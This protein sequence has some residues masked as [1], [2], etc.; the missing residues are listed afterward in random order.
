M[1]TRFLSVIIPT[2]NEKDNVVKLITE[3]KSILLTNNITFEIIFVDDASDDGTAELLD[4]ISS[5]IIKVFHRTGK[6]DLSASTFEGF[7]SAKSDIVVVMDA[8]LSHNPKYLTTMFNLIKDEKAD[9]VIGSRYIK[10]SKTTNGGGLRLIFSRIATFL[11]NRFTTVKDPTSGLYMLRKSNLH[12]ERLNSKGFKSLLEILV[13]EKFDYIKEIPIIFNNREKGKS[14]MNLREGFKYLRNILNYTVSSLFIKQFLKFFVVSGSS[15]ILNLSLL[16][17]L[18]SIFGIYYMTS[19][20]ISFGITFFINFI[21]NKLWTFNSLS[22][23]E[24]LK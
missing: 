3:V 20:I 2:L 17:L 9:L 10:D 15:V 5:D 16:Y 14:K 8:D 1:G 19:A 6:R 11:A 12:F 24:K 18:T 22:K 13:K 4:S 23:Q 7:K 21:L